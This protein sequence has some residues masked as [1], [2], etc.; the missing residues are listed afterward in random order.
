MQCSKWRFRRAGIPLKIEAMIHRHKMVKVMD[1]VGLISAGMKFR[2][3]KKLG[4]V[5]RHIPA[6]FEHRKYVG[7]TLYR[8]QA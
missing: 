6:H 1:I 4:L 8:R 5:Y 3:E 2:Y 7:Y